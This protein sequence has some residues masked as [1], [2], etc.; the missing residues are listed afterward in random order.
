MKD[1]RAG[2]SDKQADCPS[3]PWPMVRGIGV[4]EGLPGV[5]CR[6]LDR[7]GGAVIVQAYGEL[8]GS[9]RAARLREALKEHVVDE[10][11]RVI[12]LDLSRM[13]FLDGYGA[14][15]LVSVMQESERLGKRLFV[16]GADRQVRDKLRV[17]GVLAVLERGTSPGS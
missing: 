13:T 3:R 8:V 7:R 12:A 1:C 10:D 14:T 17:T 2:K 6:V 16:T 9:R 11:V 15:A 5:E 4:G